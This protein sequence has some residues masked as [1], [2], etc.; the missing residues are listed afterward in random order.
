MFFQLR[1]FGPLVLVDLVFRGTFFNL[2]FRAV[3]VVRRDCAELIFSTAVV[4]RYLR[5]YLP[6]KRA[7]VIEVA[8]MSDFSG[9]P[10]LKD[11]S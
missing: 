4:Y 9:F 6:L 7:R 8:S 5:S 11:E 10:S 3:C 1:L 2:L